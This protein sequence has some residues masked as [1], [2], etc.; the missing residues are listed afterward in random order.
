MI[1]LSAAQ[2]ESLERFNQTRVDFQFEGCLA[3]LFEKQCELTPDR[4]AVVF[5]GISVSYRD[6]NANANKVAG[7]LISK[8]I[9]P[10]QLVGISADRSVELVTGILGILKSGAAYVPFDPAYPA[11]RIS[12]M[13][14]QSGI[15]IMLT[16]TDFNDLFSGNG[17][18]I[19]D[20]KELI[21]SDSYSNIANLVSSIQ[22]EH[23]AY[24]LFTSGS[25]GMPK[26]VA[27][28]QKA[29]V[30]LIHWQNKLTNLG[31]PARTLQF[32][33]VSFDVS[34]QELFTTWT[35]GGTLY[36]ISDEMRLNAIRLL[37]FISE[38]K[39]ERLFLPFIAL[40][41]LAEVAV[42]GKMFPNC[43]KDIITAG[44]QLQIT[45]AIHQF[46]SKL[47]E[48]KLHN[49]Y[50]PTETHVVTALTLKGT[51]DQW[52]PLPPI[53]TPV[54]NTRIF[55]LNSQMMPVEQ[56][57][58]GEIYVEGEALA[59]GY[60]N[61]ADL[62][63]ERFLDNVISGYGTIYKTGD[64]GR[65]LPDG[66][67][68]YLG[69]ADNQVK[70]RGY[71]IEP[72][73]VEIAISKNPG[74]AQ[75]A[76][77]V[78]EDIP[79]DKRLVAY[80][81]N[82]AGSNVTLQ[83]IRKTI[84]ANLPEYMMPSAFV[85][86]NELPKTPSGKTDR[87]ALP[88]PDESR[89]DIGTVYTAPSSPDE[90]LIASLWSRLLHIDKIGTNDNFFDLGGNSLL[91]LQSIAILRQEHGLDIPVVKLY[92]HPSIK[93]LLLSL[94]G[95]NESLSALDA[96][97]LRYASADNTG[98]ASSKTVEDGIAIIGM[99]GRFPGAANVEEMWKNLLDGKETT[100]FFNDNEIDPWIDPQI[101][102]DPSYVKARGIISDADQFDA[103]FFGVNPRLAELMDPQQ[104]VFMEVC[105]EALENAGYHPKKYKGLIGV[106]AG[107]GNNTYYLNNVL[108]HKDAIEKV[109][110]FQVMVANEK[111]YIATRISHVMNLTGPGLSIHTA[112]STSLTAIAT[113][114][115][116]LW[117][118]QCDMAI[119]GGI[120]ITSPVNSGHLYQEGG[121]FSEDGHTRSFDAGARGTVFSDGTGVVILKRYA[122][123]V[124]DGD[125][126]Y[127]V[128]R[129]VGVNNDGSE[130]ASFTAPSVEGQANAIAAAQA[131]A[132]VTPDSISYIE[133]H[134]TATPLGDPIEVEALTLAFRGG[135]DKKQFCAIG[136]V[137]SNF[138]HL[139]AAAGVAGLIKTALA[140]HHK[141]IPASI[142]YSIPNPS[143]NFEESP[144]YVNDKLT[145]W[146]SDQHPRRA[147]V[148]SF[149][150]GGTNVHLVLEEAPEQHASGPS[151]PKHLLLLSTKGKENLETALNQLADHLKTHPSVDP[152][153]VAYTLQTG[154][155]GFNNRRY[156]VCDDVNDAVLQL[157]AKNPARSSGR[158][159]ESMA[160]G[161]AFMFPGQG[162]QYVGMGSNLYRDEIVFREAVDR[163]CDL[164]NDHL[165][166]DLRTVLYPAKGEESKAAELLQQTQYTQPSL[167]T[168]G[169]A[170]AKLW[171]SWGIQPSAL[172][173]HSIG[174]FAAACIAG[175]M[176]LEDALM[177]V[178]NRGKLMQSMPEG[179]MLSVRMAAEE[180]SPML[181]KDV[182][183]AAANGP[184]LCVIS[185][186]HES[187]HQIQEM[188]EKRDIVCKKLFT[189]HAFHS[190]MMDP[191]VEPFRALVASITLHP[192]KVPVYSTA[193]SRLLTDQ[194]ATSPDYWA[195]HLRLPVLFA[196]AIKTLWNDDP[197]LI[198]LE[199]GPRNTA[200][201]L[202]RQQATDLKKQFAVSSLPDNSED[203]AEWNTMLSAIGQ[204]WLGGIEI[205]WDAFYLLEKRKHVPLPTYPFEHKRY[206]VNPVEP[207]SGINTFHP[208]QPFESNNNILEYPQQHIE[209]SNNFANMS[210]TVSRRERI[211][212]EL[213]S[214]MEDA[215]G[216]ELATADENASF[217]ELGMDSLFLT[218]AAL[219]ISKKYGVKI[220]FRQLNESF[221]SMALLANHLDA[222]MPAEAMP[223]EQK[224]VA[225]PAPVNNNTSRPIQNFTAAQG[226]DLQWLITQQ[227]Q[228]MQQQLAMMN[229]MPAPR[230]TMQSA[231]A[232]QHVSPN[233]SEPAAAKPVSQKGGIAEVSENEKAELS[234]PFGAIARIEKSVSA[235]LSP[236]Q[237]K[238]IADFTLRYNSNTKNSK[239]YTQDH[240]AHLADPRVVTGFKPTIKELIYQVVVASSN[241]CRITDIDGNV[242]IDVL[243]GFGS[244]FLGYGSPVILP[245][246]EKQLREGIE[247]GPQHPLAGEVAKLICDFTGY[248]RAGFCNTGSEAVL[249][250]MRI[251]RTVTGRSTIVCFNGSYHGINDEVI[252]RGT[253][254]LKSFPAAAGILPEAVENMLVLDY[255]TDESLEIIRERAGDIAAVMVEP[256]QSRRAD[257]KPKAFLQEVRKITASNGALLIFDEVITGFRLLPGGAQEFYDIKA[258]LGTYGKVIGGGMPIGVIAGKK[259][260]M[261]ALDGGHWQFGDNSVPE[262]GVTYFAGTFVRH[263]LAL[264]A[265]KAVLVHLKER[266]MSIYNKLN[267]YADKLIEKVNAFTA[268]TGAPFHLVNFG[269]LFKVKWD[270][271][272]PYGELLF[273][274][275]R[276]KGIHIY[277][278]F[279]CF[280]TDAFTDED[281]DK[282]IATFIECTAELQS[283]GFL[284]SSSGNH[285]GNGTS[286]PAVSSAP[287]VPGARLGKGPDGNPGWFVPDPERP[288]K[289]R[290]VF[291]S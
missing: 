159:L 184:A 255:G 286:A 16:Q 276:D 126:I 92:Q 162:S 101:K 83:D 68:E 263:P 243:N 275:M 114:C 17:I 147:G 132:N 143:I 59:R 192:P 285:S 244:N 113:A 134:G 142:N 222:Q 236:E 100:A 24:V 21:E 38:H 158:T 78:R 278:G 141:V 122:D 119:S 168:I 40:Q 31:S 14:K 67:I 283:A 230:P 49:H 56:G 82:A 139:T 88:K 118:R 254:K 215:S 84:S 140:L 164:L 112:C 28:V 242:Y 4:T 232:V 188:L 61:R 131:H 201:S 69:R 219:T 205:N 259:E 264:A 253:K 266:G 75:V 53:G 197:S 70:I 110:P 161:V 235:E 190:P 104:R 36:L 3:Q 105:W 60:I 79:G 2:K 18:S 261:D 210:N 180:V 29:L 246:V 63:A 15:S 166:I 271:E 193:T 290:Q 93:G 178:A 13:V 73:E 284:P 272:Q 183:V 174:E 144:F 216:I 125:Q 20:I 57:E 186:P 64:L 245:A 94:G 62:T 42:N 117:N 273:L 172:T 241:G 97:K 270:V 194:E 41:H 148:S 85:F 204:L 37:E 39:I 260:Y 151:R 48:C 165:D 71:R 182:S 187:I 287:P 257:F 167:F 173:G 133:T 66:V 45:R 35:S 44:E 123:A 47:P 221:A 76:V 218:Q 185:G 107:M 223:A 10:D 239:K 65:Y 265:A 156:V 189:S 262:V 207:S 237:K 7:F 249:G 127:A 256:I 128:I 152:A 267:G 258:D 251:A 163:C 160:S 157:Q 77:A 136:S 212:A 137:K 80:M 11:D 277:D 86:L 121:M 211:I 50:G 155:A 6:L 177:L 98:N 116:S 96:A 145:P 55:I 250:A 150:V 281:V 129:G 22:P 170:L 171:E 81:V 9:G 169:Y 30:N 240:R 43:L 247:L 103:P 291:V 154:R 195:R 19:C 89:P 153:D 5:N 175:V 149:G 26:G 274:L 179:A 54:S 228:V 72:G 279:P 51:P 138:G 8:G 191:I 225:S 217:M 102:S 196:D 224:P 220:T 1:S 269:S 111:D 34:F 206:W 109:G 234:K 181:T 202:A 226:N 124:N 229:G 227:L 213:R 23:L 135:T 238:W 176:S 231:P 288:G 233:I 280:F 198:L 33:P 200:A 91:A 248:D 214:V 32:A 27:M 203:N 87:K 12:Y 90:Q 58:E 108:H 209:T 130:K 115:Q 120:A 25:T 46:F 95:K 99:S 208:Y 146:N 268:A 74:I 52:P 282:V 252:V 289:Y 106:Y 199:L